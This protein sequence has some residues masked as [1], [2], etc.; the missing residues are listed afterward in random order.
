[1]TTILNVENGKNS[2]FVFWHVK[3]PVFIILCLYVRSWLHSQ[4]S[5]KSTSGLSRHLGFAIVCQWLFN[6]RQLVSATLKTRV[7]SLEINRCLVPI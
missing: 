7:L 4:P 6:M 1:M 2:L 5:L 3:F